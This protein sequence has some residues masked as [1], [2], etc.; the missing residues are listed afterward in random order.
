MRFFDYI[1]SMDI[2]FS[3]QMLCNYICNFYFTVF[4]T[5]LIA[6]MITLQLTRGVR[7]V[8]HK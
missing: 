1:D 6:I 7:H 5:T 8:R 4:S 3:I 2:Y